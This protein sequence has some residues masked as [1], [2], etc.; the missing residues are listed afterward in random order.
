MKKVIVGSEP[1]NIITKPV[2]KKQA[3]E[4]QNQKPSLNKHKTKGIFMRIAD[5]VVD[6]IKRVF[7]KDEKSRRNRME[8]ND[9]M[10]QHFPEMVKK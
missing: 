3:R 9:F 8:Y 4:K 6:D 2:P 1:G 10:E 7:R 5:I